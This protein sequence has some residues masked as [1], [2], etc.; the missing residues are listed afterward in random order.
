MWLE[1]LLNMQAEILNGVAKEASLYARISTEASRMW[2]VLVG[3]L[4]DVPHSA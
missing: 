3:E 2:D 4:V 1:E